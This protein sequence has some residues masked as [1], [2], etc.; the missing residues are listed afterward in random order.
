MA[1]TTG[2]VTDFEGDATEGILLIENWNGTTPE[3]NV[4]VTGGTST[5]DATT[6]T[7]GGGSS[8]EE[9]FF[10]VVNADSK[11]MTAVYDYLSARMAEDTLVDPF[12]DV[13]IWGE[14]EHAAML[15]EGTAGFFTNRIV[16]RAQGVWVRDRG[17]GTIDFF[18]SDDGTE[19]TPPVTVNLTLTNLRDNTEVRVCDA[20]TGVEL[21]GIENATDGTSDDRSVTFSLAAG[22]LVDIRFA[23]GTAADGNVYTVPDRNS[24]LDFTW[25]STATSLPITQVLDPDF[26]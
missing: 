10:W 24:I 11:S 18:T 21:A 1:D 26:R 14:D 16:N 22:L 19:V 7:S 17:G 2:E 20:I 13:H 5:F 12:I 6:N 25:P 23:H 9:L 15:F 4:N 8:V 3:N